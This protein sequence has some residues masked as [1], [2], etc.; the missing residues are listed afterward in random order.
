MA[1]LMLLLE[2]VC[3][4]YRDGSFC[5]TQNYYQF[6]ADIVKFVLFSIQS[7]EIFTNNVRSD[8]IEQRSGAN[9]VERHK[10]NK[11]NHLCC[12]FWLD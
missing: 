6:V 11:K 3:T 8:N 7:L 4:T 10:F 2:E 12:S 9:V 5:E 1:F